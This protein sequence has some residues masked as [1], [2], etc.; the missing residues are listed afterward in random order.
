LTTKA[1]A[2]RKILF[3]A[4]ADWEGTSRLL[5]EFGRL[6]CERAVMSPPGFTIT[7]TRFAAAHF[8]LPPHRGLKLGLLASRYYRVQVW[9]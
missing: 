4:L 6:G 2:G 8:R 9:P 5:A 1:T 3:L 7:A